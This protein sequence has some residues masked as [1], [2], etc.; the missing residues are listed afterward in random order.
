MSEIIDKYRSVKL[1]KK[2]KLIEF[3]GT[4]LGMLTLIFLFIKLLFF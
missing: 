2:E 1:D 4:A 3:L